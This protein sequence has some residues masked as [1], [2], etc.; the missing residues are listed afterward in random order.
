MRELGIYFPGLKKDEVH[1]IYARMQTK[2][3]KNITNSSKTQYLLMLGVKIIVDKSFNVQ[4]NFSNLINDKYMLT[5]MDHIDFTNSDVLFQS[6]NMHNCDTIN[7]RQ[8]YQGR[9]IQ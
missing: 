3:G 7:S 8:N 4:H 6:L 9:Y 1:G 5:E 2:L